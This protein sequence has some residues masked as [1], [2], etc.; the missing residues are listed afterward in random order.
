MKRRATKCSRCE[1]PPRPGQAYCHVCHAVYRRRYRYKDLSKEAKKRQN[2]HAYVRTYVKRG[3]IKREPCEVC[4]SRQSEGHHTDYSKPLQVTWLCRE[5]H[6]ALEGKKM[7]K[8]HMERY[9][10]ITVV[11]KARRNLK[12]LAA[13]P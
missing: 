9:P 5:H 12:S 11:P 6:L 1:N 7:H 4:G 3:S 2:A 10:E 8:F 13:L